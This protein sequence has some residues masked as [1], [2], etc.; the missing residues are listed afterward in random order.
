MKIRFI[1]HEFEVLMHNYVEGPV[2]NYTEGPESIIWCGEHA[3]DNNTMINEIHS[4]VINEHR[5]P[6]E[7]ELMLVDRYR[8]R[9]ENY[10]YEMQRR[11]GQY[12]YDIKTIEYVHD[13]LKEVEKNFFG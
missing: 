2:D 1:F 11:L 5:W 12:L 3:K 4:K 8:D 10:T 13:V 9:L 6:T 7:E